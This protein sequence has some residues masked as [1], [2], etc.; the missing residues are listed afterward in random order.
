MGHTKSASGFAMGFSKTHM[1]R[2]FAFDEMLR[3]FEA[4]LGKRLV[5]FILRAVEGRSGGLP[6]PP[7]RASG[8]RYLQLL[9]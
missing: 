9:P 8:G 7:V 4:A 3:A 5:V 6:A 2:F 1:P